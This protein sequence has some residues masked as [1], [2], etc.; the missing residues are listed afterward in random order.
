MTIISEMKKDPF[1]SNPLNH[2]SGRGSHPITGRV[3]SKK[4]KVLNPDWVSLVLL[5]GFLV[6]LTSACKTYQPSISAVEMKKNLDYLASDSLKGRYPGSLEDTEL[7]NFL[8]SEFEKYGLEAPEGG[9]IQYFEVPSTLSYPEEN[10]ALYDQQELTFGDQYIPLILSSSQNLTA[11]VIFGG[12]GFEVSEGSKSRNDYQNISLNGE[13]VL[14]VEGVPEEIPEFTNRSDIRDKVRLA[15]EKGAGGVIFTGNNDLSPETRPQGFTSGLIPVIRINEKM[16]A[17]LLKG[18]GLS[19]A[20]LSQDDVLRVPDKEYK[21]SLHFTAE[22]YI[23]RQ[24]ARTGNVIGILKGFDEE[25]RNEW[26]LIGAH[27]DHLG[28][29]GPNSSS[30]RPDTLAVHNGADDNASGVAAV[31]ELAQYFASDSS[32]QRTMVFATFGA[33]EMGLLGSKYMSDHSFLDITDMQLMLNMDMV[34]RMRKDSVLQI[35]GVGTSP[36]FSGM[37]D[38]LNQQWKLK[39]EK[40]EAGYGPSDHASFYAKNVPVLFFST[41]AHS[42]YH[43]P[44]DDV[45]S[46]NFAGMELAT[47]Y[48]ASVASILTNYPERL[49]F[50]EAGPRAGETRSYTQGV[51]LGIM[52]DVGGGEE[53]LKVLAVT[54]GRPAYHGGVKKGDVIIDIEGESIKNVYDY[55]YQLKKFKAGQSI[56]VKVYRNGEEIDLLIKL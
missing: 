41:G 22:I 10:R 1:S 43:T 16:T 24:V 12:Y 48:I 5:L 14:I 7:L 39:L 17:E 18:M 34:G 31:L 49:D 36:V 19:P 51:T 44:Y 33:E 54:E 56:I 32:N 9:Y 53:G 6:F 3:L 40:S 45:D 42:D 30:R 47:R 27:H 38:S 23:N 2:E 35:G 20:L 8:A 28:M 37:L 15:Q 55:M 13:W 52:P 46:L 25:L 26:V 21:T 50:T 11:P 29:G 4:Y